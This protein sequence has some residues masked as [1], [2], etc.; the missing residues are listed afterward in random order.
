MRLKVGDISG[1]SFNNEHEST[2]GFGLTVT[3]VVA[4]GELRHGELTGRGD[5]GWEIMIDDG[6]DLDML[7]TL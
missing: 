3:V 4:D 6:G 7:V 1:S 5:V 2:H